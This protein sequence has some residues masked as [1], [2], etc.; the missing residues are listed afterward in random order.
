MSSINLTINCATYSSALNAIFYLWWN[1]IFLNSLVLIGKLSRC[2]DIA[3]TIASL[4]KIRNYALPFKVEAD[5]VIRVSHR[6]VLFAGGP[7]R[8]FKRVS[9]AI[10]YMTHLSIYTREW[11]SRTRSPSR[12]NNSRNEHLSVTRAKQLV[13]GLMSET[14][15]E[16]GRHA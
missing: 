15:A 16:I 11:W 5:L 10:L 7:L 6:R 4:I 9:L 13:S 8:S 12:I 2:L 14:K 3:S 1:S